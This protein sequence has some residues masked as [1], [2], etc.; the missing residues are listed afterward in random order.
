M[1]SPSVPNYALRD[2]V[3]STLGPATLE[4]QRWKQGGSHFL[5]K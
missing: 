4:F 1:G 5:L 2:G 3:A